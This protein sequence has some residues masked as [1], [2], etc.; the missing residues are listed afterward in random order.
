MRHS[1]K[2]LFLTLL[3]GITLFS[4]SKKE[5]LLSEE[6]EPEEVAV[7]ETFVEGTILSPA[8][9][10]CLFGRDDE[11]HSVI[12]LYAG[13]KISVLQIDGVTDT[14]FVPDKDSLPQKNEN[15]VENQ[16][17]PENSESQVAE[18]IEVMGTKYVHVVHDNVD[19]W[20]KD[21][22]FAPECENAVVIEKTFAYSD[23]SLSQ[24][25]DSKQNP[26]KFSTFIAKSIEKD[27]EEN[28]ENPKSAKI[29]FYD[30][31]EK[32][33]REA[34]VPLSA[35]STRKDDIVV[36][37]IAES[38]KTTKRAAPRNELFAEAAKYKPSAPVR[39]ALNAQRE[40]KVKNNY[41]EVVKSMQRMGFGV[42][43]NELLTVDQSKDPFK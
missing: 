37:R 1:E 43:V 7:Q 31:A 4:C 23:S 38:L 25:I 11:M 12:K 5:P 41:Q 20:L 29:F 13:N 9:Q 34:F 17:N 30:T 26:L 28:S 16:Q 42:N 39:A 22:V 40:E 15:S 24:K 6:P 35:I 32:S 14:K 2:F 18:E 21:S 27:S 36:A 19:F 10:L 33:V 8:A 3:L